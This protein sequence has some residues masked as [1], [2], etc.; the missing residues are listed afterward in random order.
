MSLDAGDRWQTV[1]RLFDAVC[2]QPEQA[3]PEA[4]SALC[5]EQSLIDETLDLL[6]AQTAMLGRVGLSLDATLATIHAMPQIGSHL[7]P[8]R[9]ARLL[10]NGGMGTVFLAERADA[11]YRRQVAIKVLRGGGEALRARIRDES[12]I[13]ADL[14][15][16]DIARLYDAGLDAEGHPYLVME[17]IDGPP[18][19]VACR[20]RRLGLQQRLRLFETICRTVQVAHAQ[21][22]VHCDIKPGNV[23]VRHDLR[24][25]L[26]DFGIARLLD[27]DERRPEGTCF[28]PGYAAPEVAQ[29]RSPTLASDVFSLGV[30]LTE[31]LADQPLRRNLETLGDPVPAP[32]RV[33]DSA[34][35]WK[36]RLPG[37]LDAIVLR[38]CAATP[39]ERYPSAEALADDVARYL[40]R[41]PV[42]A[43]A[44]GRLH[45]GTLLLRR[46][47]RE[48]LVASA[49]LLLTGGFM[50]SLQQAR[51][52]AE[53]NAAAA[54]STTEFL[55]AS[56]D[57]ADPGVRGATPLSAREI[58]DLAARRLQTQ[59]AGSP[60]LR[61]RLQVALGRAYQNLGQPAE[62]E[63]LLRAAAATLA[64]TDAPA[65]DRVAMSIALAALLADIRQYQQALDQADQA[66]QLLQ[67]APDPTAQAEALNARGRAL[68][69]LARHD[70]ARSA[71]I[72][73]IELGT[74]RSAAALQRNRL[75]AMVNLGGMYRDQG[76]LAASETILRQAL[77]DAAGR[78]HGED[79][80]DYQRGMQALS[81]TLFAQGRIDDALALAARGLELTHALF[82]SDSSHTASAEAQLAGQYLDL[83]RYD[84]SE[85]HFRT[86]REISRQADGEGSTAYGSRVY[87]S[88]ILEEA[89]GDYARA[90]D[91]YRQA[92][93]IQRARLGQDHADSLNLEMGLARL[94]LRTQRIQEAEPI[95][96]RVG[97][98][99]R[100]RFAA[101]AP[102]LLALEL[103]EI[104]WLIRAGR[105]ADAAA[106]IAAFAAAQHDLPPWL[107]IRLQMQQALLAQRSHA[108]DAAARWQAAVA[109]FATLYGADSTATAKWRVPLAES[110]VDAGRFDA[111]RAEIER[112]CPRLGTLSPDSEFLGRIRALEPQLG[113]F[114]C[115]PAP[116]AGEAPATETTPAVP[117]AG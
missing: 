45:R 15:H 76:Q 36:R 116:I 18:L 31:L 88:G 47:W 74:E 14:Q 25:V 95:L 37:D 60:L 73:S 77:D 114:A 70:E 96:Q 9:L 117:A 68:A 112:A 56:F 10:G 97:T 42:R 49:A 101:D 5:D 30:L 52:E 20:E 58:L 3:W 28:T 11:L 43:R 71:F 29:G 67:A 115:G 78:V 72:A 26:L 39:A 53:R 38:A 1:R 106:A 99:W 21:M 89:R 27:D 81:Q 8:W 32:S 51:D 35:A 102:D 82:G 24:P 75:R 104:E 7:G 44:A 12:Q 40:R 46:R 61:A 80:L 65:Q 86:A 59:Q 33:A 50:L 48:G 63:T 64:T 17:Y 110:L 98:V 93:A 94:L 111:A 41:E 113:R 83:G 16:P 66:L 13:L 108:P 54:T 22:V 19:D 87:A 57:A 103:I 90:E 109:T 92:L 2:E 105:H 84:E 62:A 107:H 6:R 79:G 4:L 55:I 100:Q 91:F 69:G 23:L 85:R 34:L